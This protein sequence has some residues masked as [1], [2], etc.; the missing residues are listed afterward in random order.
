[1]GWVVTSLLDVEPTSAGAAGS[2]VVGRS[3][4]LSIFGDFQSLIDLCLLV[5]GPVYKGF[6]CSMTYLCKGAGLIVRV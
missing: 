6:V 4:R 5:L 1:M 3:L 2:V